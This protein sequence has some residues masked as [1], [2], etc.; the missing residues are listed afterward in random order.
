M[1]A[2]TAKPKRGRTEPRG[3][4]PA[5]YGDLVD[6]KQRESIYAIQARYLAEIKVLREQITSLEAKV[7]EEM[8]AVLTDEQRDKL[9][10]WREEGKAKR[11]ADATRKRPEED[12]Q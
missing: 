10:R 8:E 6:T 5:Y 3:R 1:A 2:D 12:P 11:I 4:L 9:H 7:E